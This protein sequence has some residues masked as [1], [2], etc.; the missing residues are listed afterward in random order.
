MSNLSHLAETLP[1]VLGSLLES[2]TLDR[3]ELTI[4]VKPADILKVCEILRTHAECRFEMLMDLCGVDYLYY[5]VSEWE[6][7]SATAKGFE[8]AVRPISQS[9][10]NSQWKKPRFAVVYHLLSIALNHRLRVKAFVPDDKPLIDSVVGIWAG[11]NWYEREAFD[12]Y[13][14]LFN[15]HPDLRRLLTDYGFIGHPF[16]KDF[17]LSG[18]VEV[19]YDAKEQRVIYEPVDIV[20]RTLVPKV[21]RKSFD[22]SEDP[23]G[24]AH[25]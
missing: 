8:R 11:A 16:R 18:N 9:V 7:T 15:R 20:P 12:L 2:I 5:G 21:I 1:G 24:G 4:E 23:Q 25:V 10:P 19:R 13:G 14:I 3:G 17:P 6:T 22:E